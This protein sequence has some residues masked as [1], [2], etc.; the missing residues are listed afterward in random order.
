PM[1]KDIDT[2]QAE[3][4]AKLTP[5]SFAVNGVS[6]TLN[7]DV[8]RIRA[9]DQNLAVVIP[10][11]DPKLKDEIIVI[12]AHYDHLGRGNEFS[13][14]G[15]SGMGQIHR[16]ADDNASG[17]SSVLELADALYKN[18][19]ALKRTVWIMFFGAEELGTLGSNYFIRT[20]PDNFPIPKVAAMLN[21][22]MVGRCRDHKV[23]VYGASTGVGFED[24]L[25]NANE[26]VKME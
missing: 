9:V 13:L 26:N 17:V 15:K 7:A 10:G 14:A 12:G 4:D 16:G 1:K 6:I 21:L 23:M 5:Q 11:T 8:Q 18:R 24:V 2:L 25:K 19:A 20:P 3:I 22:D